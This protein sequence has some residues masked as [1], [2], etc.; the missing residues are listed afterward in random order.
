MGDESGETGCGCG[1]DNACCKGCGCG[2]H[3]AVSEA[4]H[5][6]RARG[7]VIA[8]VAELACIV[9]LMAIGL[10]WFMSNWPSDY[11]G[12]GGG[13]YAHPGGVYVNPGGVMNGGGP[14]AGN[15]TGGAPSGSSGSSSGSGTSSSGF[16]GSVT[17]P[18]LGHV[19]WGPGS[20][21]GSSS[22]SST[23]PAASIN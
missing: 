20:G 12:P 1:S 21:S 18:G 22:S 9:V 10:G 6:R 3:G 14:E 19:S 15:S 8:V 7:L 4:R 2:G 5:G 17:V 11:H 16:G 23:A 13:M